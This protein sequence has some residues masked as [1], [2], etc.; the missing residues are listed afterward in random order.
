MCRV[1][2][3]VYGQERE[4]I[5]TPEIAAVLY[6]ELVFGGP[7]AWGWASFNEADSEITWAKQPGR[8]DSKNARRRQLRQI[9]KDAK[10]FI[11]HTRFATHGSPQ[12]N[13]NNHPILHDNIVGIHNGI[14]R[15]HEEILKE[16]G[17]HDDGSEVDSEA[18]FAAVNK[19][20]LQNGLK[21]VKGDMVAVFADAR[22]PEFLYIARSHGRQVTLGWTDKG[23][24]I[25]ASEI[26]A[27]KR[28]ER[29]GIKFT[30]FS[31]VSENRLLTLKDGKITN[32]VRYAPVPVR[33]KWNPGSLAV[34]GQFP[35]EHSYTSQADHDKRQK[36]LEETFGV[37]RELVEHFKKNRK[38]DRKPTLKDEIRL[39]RASRR[40][41]ILFPKKHDER[42]AAPESSWIWDEE[43]SWLWDD[44]TNVPV[45]IDGRES[46]TGLEMFW[47]RGQYL[48][49]QEYEEA[50]LFPELYT[51]D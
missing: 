29:H 4:E 48:T 11:L 24:I 7:H 28:L 18:I 33:S 10:W 9:D 15:N 51:Q 17:R 41:E 46:G 6:K 3:I 5:T 19:W 21:R 25:F 1:G 42:P 34:Y 14:L 45:V 22:R 43:D 35:W 27:L 47:F 40:G 16:T 50:L 26:Q 8:C 38:S 30:K 36:E 37:E 49:R 31:T 32:R 2:G 12:D 39:D 44:D 20:G 13:L 23:N